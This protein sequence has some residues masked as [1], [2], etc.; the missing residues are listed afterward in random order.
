M[1]TEIGLNG[2]KGFNVTNA[3]INISAPVGEPNLHGNTFIPNPSLVTVAL[4]NVSLSIST[5]KAG[6][7][8]SATIENM[9]LVPGDNNLP[10]VSVINQTAIIS[11]LDANGFVDLTITATESVF[12][13]QHLTYY[14]SSRLESRSRQSRTNIET[15]ESFGIQRTQTHSQR[16][17]DFGR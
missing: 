14:V 10:L 5:A 16:Q 13:G 6:V 2:L 1:L 15:G 9:T 11:S 7:V 12:N 3:R 8:G 4:G 17:A